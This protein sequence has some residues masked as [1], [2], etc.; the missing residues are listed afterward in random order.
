LHEW[1]VRK[2]TFA[3]TGRLMPDQYSVSHNPAA[4]QFEI[5]T[6]HGTA[7]LRYAH[8]GAELDLIHT[9]VPEA[10]EGKGY[11]AALAKAALEYAAAEDMKVIPSC[12]FVSTYIR[13][14]PEHAGLV[15]AR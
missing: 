11:G 8:R 9:E 12:P 15:A 5:R 3:L 2:F 4:G 6:E 14:H 13:R 1:A 10:L 7:L